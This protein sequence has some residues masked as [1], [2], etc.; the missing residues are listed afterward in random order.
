MENSFAQRCFHYFTPRE[1]SA[2]ILS[3]ARAWHSVLPSRLPAQAEGVSWLVVL[4]LSHVPR[5]AIVETKHFVR[6]IEA[7]HQRRETL[8]HAVTGLRINLQMRVEIVIASGSF[9]SNIVRV[10]GRRVLIL[11]NTRASIANAQGGKEASPIISGIEIPRHRGL[12]LQLWN[13]R[14]KRQMTGARI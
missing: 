8:R 11:E 10:V 4:A 3:D 6:K 9:W 2:F 7:L 14:A 12:A 5:A 1:F 13:I